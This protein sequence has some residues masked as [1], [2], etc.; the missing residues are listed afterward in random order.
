MQY[1]TC[2]LG[3][4]GSHGCDFSP[5]LRLHREVSRGRTTKMQKHLRRSAV[6]FTVL[7][8]LN[9]VRVYFY[10]YLIVSW[11][12]NYS[13][14]SRGRL[15]LERCSERE[16]TGLLFRPTAAG[17]RSGKMAAVGSVPGFTPCF[18]N[19]RLSPPSLR[20]LQQP[21]LPARKP[22]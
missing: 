20:T 11:C 5:E 4:Y 6:V 1:K 22:L 16:P 21:F 18:L 15:C 19:R 17:H 9:R 2:H 7:Q 8:L 14:A 12:F 10:H 3:A 13:S